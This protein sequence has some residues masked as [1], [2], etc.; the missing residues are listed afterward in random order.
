MNRVGGE[1]NNNN[2]GSMMMQNDT[3][4]TDSDMDEVVKKANMDKKS[5]KIIHRAVKGW[6]EK[7]A[8]QLNKGA[9]EDSNADLLAKKK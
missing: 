9:G 6:D 1:N 7:I 3:S 2:Q 5:K 4:A 8:A